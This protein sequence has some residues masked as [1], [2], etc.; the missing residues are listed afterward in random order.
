MDPISETGEIPKVSIDS[1]GEEE[2]TQNI[3]ETVRSIRSYQM[4]VAGVAPTLGKFGIFIFI[5]STISFDE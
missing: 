1:S 3:K 5:F 2:N 4:P